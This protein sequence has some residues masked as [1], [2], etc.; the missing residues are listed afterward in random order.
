MQILQVDENWTIHAEK[1][2][3][4]APQDRVLIFP[5]REITNLCLRNALYVALSSLLFSC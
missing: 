2:V 3:L 4:F 1:L 5:E